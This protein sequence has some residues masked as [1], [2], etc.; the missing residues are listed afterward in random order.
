MKTRTQRTASVLVAAAAL[1]LASCGAKTIEI[2]AHAEPAG[3]ST[4][5][6]ESTLDPGTSLASSSTIVDPTTSIAAA[7]STAAPTTTAGAS[8]AGGSGQRSDEAFCA[9]AGKLLNSGFGNFSGLDVRNLSS[10][11]LRASFDATLDSVSDALAEMDATAPAE[12][13]ADMH[14]VATN[15]T[16][17]LDALAS[18]KSFSDLFHDETWS[19]K[20]A[21]VNGDSARASEHVVS[22]ALD[23]CGFSIKGTVAG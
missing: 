5:S 8:T 6:V 20:A 9:A 1:S 19:G 3:S 18:A 11:Q 14:T 10:D 17:T 2:T 12:I 7:T 21:T 4:A 16:P 15:I 22:Y 13:E 23:H